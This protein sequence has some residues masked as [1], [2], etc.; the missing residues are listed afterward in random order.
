MKNILVLMCLAVV[1]SLCACC[2]FGLIFGEEGYGRKRFSAPT[3]EYLDYLEHVKAQPL[4]WT[5]ANI[6]GWAISVP[7]GI[8]VTD[9]V[10]GRDGELWIIPPA[11]LIGL[12]PGLALPVFL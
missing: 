8:W 12:A 9:L 3:T 6:L 4:S 2:E 10:G 5:L 7:S 11:L 1:L